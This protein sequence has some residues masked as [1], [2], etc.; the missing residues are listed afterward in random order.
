MHESNIPDNNPPEPETLFS[1]SIE[2]SNQQARPVPRELIK[3]VIARILTDA[4]FFSGEISVAVVDDRVMQELNKRYLGHDYATDVLSFVLE[5]NLAKNSLVGEV[6]VSADTAESTA[7]KLKHSLSGE[8]MLYVV[9]GALHLVGYNDKTSGD[10]NAMSQAEKKYLESIGLVGF[11][12]DRSQT[13]ETNDPT[14]HAPQGGR[15]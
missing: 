6:I 11:S 5:Q 13:R 3:T 4:R 12:V 8:L 2:I 7:D 9:H 1:G 14:L 15:S 10:K